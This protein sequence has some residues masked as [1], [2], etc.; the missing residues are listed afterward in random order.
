MMKSKKLSILMI[1]AVF[2]ASI[3]LTGCDGG[4]DSAE[5]AALTN[6]V[7]PASTN[8]APAADGNKGGVAPPGITGP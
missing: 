1:L 3:V 5:A 8:A 7:D 2:A 4:G 6:K